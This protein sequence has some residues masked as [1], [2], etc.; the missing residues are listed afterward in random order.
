M[1]HR[2]GT[3]WIVLFGCVLCLFASLIFCVLAQKAC[4]YAQESELR[5]IKLVK[6][7]VV[8]TPQ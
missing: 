6:A 5:M 8:E 7:L 2:N 1:N 3:E 4:W